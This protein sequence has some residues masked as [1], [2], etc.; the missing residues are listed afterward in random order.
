MNRAHPHLCC[1]LILSVALV[2]ATPAFAEGSLN[3]HVRNGTTGASAANVPVVL[4]Q[5]QGGMETVA[6][7]KTDSQGRFHFDNPAIGKKPML[8]RAIYRGVNF[9]QPLPPG[10]DTAEVEVFEPSTDPKTISVPS[11]LIVF[12]PNGS[13]LLIGEEYVV[14]NKS[15]P[16]SAFF[17]EQGNFE[18]QIPDHAELQQVAAWGPSGM[19]VVQGTMDR[20]ANRHA[21]AFAFRPGESGVRM[22]YQLSYPSSHA[23][24]R[25]ASPYLINRMVMVAAPTVKL[26]SPGFQPAGS[27]Q[28]MNLYARDAIPAGAVFDVEVS[29]TAPAPSAQG[30]P[31]GSG[32]EP[33]P[34]RGD[35]RAIQTL[36]SRI[37]SL[38]WPIISGFG[39]LFLLGAMFLWRKPA[40][41]FANGAPANASGGTF[42]GARGVKQNAPSAEQPAVEILDP[43]ENTTQQVQ[44]SLDGLKDSLFRLELR[45]QAGTVSDD[46]YARERARFEQILRELVKG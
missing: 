30:G 40:A 35:N 12:Q 41:A 25:V 24:V 36:P 29:G 5:L 22:S 7:T 10:R 3:G 23:V 2:S 18:F 9:H 43:V 11:R 31:A 14:Q 16:P 4:I 1:I 44:T 17:K 19:P 39:A 15:S 13:N 42:A 45:H 8:V 21:I 32:G 6:N 37:D 20:G 34:E 27:E 33:S 26:D 38:K 46:E 28:G